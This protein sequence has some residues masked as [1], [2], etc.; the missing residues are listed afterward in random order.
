MKHALA[1]IRRIAGTL[2]IVA[3]IVA[4]TEASANESPAAV[5]EAFHADLLAVMKEAIDLGPKGRYERLSNPINQA[6][7][8]RLTIRIAT[9]SFWRKANEEQRVRLVD[10]FRRLSISNYAAQFDGYSGQ[11][12]RTVEIRQG[13]QKTV[14]VQTQLVRPDDG[15]IGLTYVLKS[16]NENDW[17][18][19]DV[20]LGDDIS[21]LAV[22]RSEYRRI[23]D[24]HGID[25]L[26]TTIN[27]KTNSLIA[28]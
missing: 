25:G 8:L 11:S 6:F 19:V 27:D 13:P 2:F 18:I 24:N 17:Q 12:F 23:L 15:P 20:L 26:I 5:V 14:L 22:R 16:R 10:A 21:Q 7:N 1:R 3:A 9:G 4:A 28:R